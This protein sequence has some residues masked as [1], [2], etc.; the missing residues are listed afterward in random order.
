[1][2][3]RNDITAA[4]TT[5]LGA[6]PGEGTPRL[7]ALWDAGRAEEHAQRCVLAHYL[8]DPEPHLTDEVRWDEIALEEFTRHRP[9]TTVGW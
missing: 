9:N 2:T 1:M 3:D 5:V 4:S 6:D 7:R 8:A